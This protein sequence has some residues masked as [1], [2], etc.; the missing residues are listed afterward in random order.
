MLEIPKKA[1]EQPFIMKIRKSY[2]NT[3]VKIY[4]RLKQKSSLTF[5]PDPDS[6]IQAIK[7]VNLQIKIW[8]QS[9]KQNMTFPSSGQNGWKWC[10]DKLIMA[11][12]WFTR[13][14]LRLTVI[15]RSHKV[16]VTKKDVYLSADNLVDDEENITES[17][18]ERNQKLINVSP[19]SENS[20]SS[21]T[22]LNQISTFGKKD[23]LIS[24]MKVVMK[25]E[26]F[27]SQ[28]KIIQA[29]TK[30]TGKFLTFFLVKILVI[31]GYL[32]NCKTKCFI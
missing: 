10:N 22:K 2:A 24:F 19:S 1:L 20:D 12:V 15:K 5:P 30:V 7:R 16:K 6:V 28:K 4:K 3:K 26:M 27:K 25:T 13:N 17:K 9:L 11:S 23:S 8:L 21:I 32:K 18:R 29:I 14:Q 31:H